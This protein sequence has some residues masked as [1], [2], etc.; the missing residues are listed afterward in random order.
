MLMIAV[1]VDDKS[2]NLHR[3]FYRFNLTGQNIK[4]LISHKTTVSMV[5][6]QKPVGV[7]MVSGHMMEQVT[8]LEM[9]ISSD[10]NTAERMSG[11][12]RDTIKGNKHMSTH[13]V[14]F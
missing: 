9:E 13:R 1:H 12:L 6:P 8:Y 14:M 7:L 3:L 5:S 10:R 4:M 2:D 11:Y